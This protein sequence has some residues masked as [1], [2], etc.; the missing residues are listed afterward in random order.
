M[1]ATNAGHAGC[2]VLP[3]RPGAVSRISCSVTARALLPHHA[4][5]RRVATLRRTRS[6]TPYSSQLSQGHHEPGDD[7]GEG[8]CHRV[9]P[10]LGGAESGLDALSWKQRT[11]G[12]LRLLAGFALRAA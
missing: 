12:H 7:A 10:A 5:R 2:P 8:Q 4:R 6:A 11:D 3:V 1:E 9:A